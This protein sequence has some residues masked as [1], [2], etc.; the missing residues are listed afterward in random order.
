MIALTADIEKVF[1]Q[2]GINPNDR[3][4]LRLLWFED[5]FAEVPKIVRN[6]FT[7]VLFG[8][9]SSIYLFN[10]T[11]QKHAKTYNFH[12]E[13]IDKVVNCFYVD[14]FSRGENSF[15]KNSELNKKSE[16]RFIEGL[17]FLRK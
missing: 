9:T 14:G 8:M 17:F 2:I 15:K 10:G 12:V 16:L 13:F 6:R 4:Y 1:L 7:R 3:D 5:V 11:V